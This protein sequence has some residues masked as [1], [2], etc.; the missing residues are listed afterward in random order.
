MS[1]F[2]HDTSFDQAGGVGEDVMEG[3]W[4]VPEREIDVT[5]QPRWAAARHIRL[6]GVCLSV[7]GAWVL[8]ILSP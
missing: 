6:P 3:Q 8:R 1:P 4:G 2:C 7:L 5:V